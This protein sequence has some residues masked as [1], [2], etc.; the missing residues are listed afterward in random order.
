MKCHCTQP[1]CSLQLR[2]VKKLPNCGLCIKINCFCLFTS[3]KVHCSGADTSYFNVWSDIIA[4]LPHFLKCRG[5][6]FYFVATLRIL[7]FPFRTS[8]D[9]EGYFLYALLTNQKEMA[10]AMASCFL[11][12]LEVREDHQTS[13]LEAINKIRDEGAAYGY[14]R[15][16]IERSAADISASA[17]GNLSDWWINQ[18]DLQ[19]SCHLSP[20]VKKHALHVS[21]RVKAFGNFLDEMNRLGFMEPKFMKLASKLVFACS[22]VHDTE[23]SLTTAVKPIV[24]ELVDGLDVKVDSTRS[25]EED[26][27]RCVTSD[28]TFQVWKNGQWIAIVCWELKR[29]IARGNSNPDVKN[30]G[31]FVRFQKKCQRQS[32]PMLLISI[33]GFSHM[34]VFGGVWNGDDCCFDPL[35]LP[36][37][38]LFVPSDPLDILHK[39]A[40][41]LRAIHKATAHLKEHYARDDSIRHPYYISDQNFKSTK[42]FPHKET[43]FEAEKEGQKVVVKFSRKYGLNAHEELAKSNLAPEVISHETLAGGWNAVVMK[44]VDGTA[45][46]DLTSVSQETKNGLKE[47]LQVLRNA[48]FVHGNLRPQNILVTGDQHVCVIDFDWAGLAGEAHYPS[49]INL[50]PTCGWHQDVAPFGLIDVEHDTFQIEKMIGN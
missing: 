3:I 5:P 42:N 38:L 8:Q 11:T 16:R 22:Q 32:A 46:S 9:A 44:K 6:E 41:M 18:T 12:K 19:L 34:Q 28:I 35:S 23:Y 36:L 29:D 30:M 1:C 24:T 14:K 7:I 10:I 26:A 20:A 13:I 37:S 48:N 50:D 49:D 15:R 43:V 40:V 39:V 4:L 21:L 17:F 2:L 27:T 33:A 31:H 25:E 45:V 47:V